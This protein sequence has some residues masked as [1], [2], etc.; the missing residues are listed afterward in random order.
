MRLANQAGYNIKDQT[1]FLQFQNKAYPSHKKN[2]VA[3]WNS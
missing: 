2:S 1:I 3:S